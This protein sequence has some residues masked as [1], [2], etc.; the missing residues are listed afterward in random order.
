MGNAQQLATAQII[1]FQTSFVVRF[2]FDR[3][4]VVRC[5]PK[6]CIDRLDTN[7][8]TRIIWQVDAYRNVIWDRKL[9]NQK[10]VDD[11]VYFNATTNPIIW[12]HAISGCR[13]LCNSKQHNHLFVAA[14]ILN[15]ITLNLQT[16]I[17]S[18]FSIKIP[19]STPNSTAPHSSAPP[20]PPS[21]Q[22]HPLPLI[23]FVDVG[24]MAI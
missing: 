17:Y 24:T 7:I 11:C 13:W 2:Q 18:W 4:D 19:Q 5:G 21:C 12:F 22:H 20:P 1:I 6:K 23:V 3:A 8:F 10:S 15:P 9:F 16:T 14:L